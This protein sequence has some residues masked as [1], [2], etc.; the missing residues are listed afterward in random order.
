MQ[1]ITGLLLLPISAHQVGA[2]SSEWGL[3]LVYISQA[4]TSG[5]S[6]GHK[7]KPHLDTTAHMTMS[8]ETRSN[9]CGRLGAS[10][11]RVELLGTIVI[12][13]A[14][15]FKDVVLTALSCCFAVWGSLR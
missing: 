1:S 9:S 3:K 13:P 14:L 4:H 6:Q 7:E 5:S 11:S 2:L 15:A 10:S 8:L 12:T